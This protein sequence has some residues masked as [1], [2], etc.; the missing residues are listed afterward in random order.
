MA[1]WYE[2]QT[3]V[4]AMAEWMAENYACADA[5]VDMLR[6]PARWT[7]HWEQRDGH[8]DT[9]YTRLSCYLHRCGRCHTLTL[10]CRLNLRDLPGED[11]TLYLCESCVAEVFR[12]A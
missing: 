11:E 5:V 7:V 6:S 3:N 12:V 10:E 8:H 4:L 9:C 2:S 1:E